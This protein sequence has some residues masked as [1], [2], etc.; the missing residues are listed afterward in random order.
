MGVPV[1]CPVVEEMLSPAGR[2]VADHD[3]MVAVD[4]ESLADRDS[5]F[6]ALPLVE[7]CDAG[8]VTVT[9]LVTVQ[10]KLAEPL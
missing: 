1:I 9:V 5:V 10:V 6:M 4:E 7:D 8:L 2:P 3:V